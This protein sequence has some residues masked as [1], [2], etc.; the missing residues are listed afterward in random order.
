MAGLFDM[1]G[2]DEA[3][4]QRQLDEQRAAKF[5][6]QTQEQRLAG[7]GYKAGAGL[8]RGL[9][10]A[11]GV[12][13][14][15]PTIRQAAELRRMA[16][17][18]DVSSPEGLMQMAQALRATNPQMAVQ[19][20][21]KAQSMRESLAKTAKDTATANRERTASVPEK[22]QTAQRIAAIKQAIPAYE[23]A[24]DTASA[25]LLKNELKSL[26]PTASLSPFGKLLTEAG[27]AEGSDQYKKLVKDFA[28]ATLAGEKKGKGT[29]IT[30]V[31]GK[32]AGDIV[33]LRKDVQATTKP[34][35]DQL[36]AATDAIELANNA[37]KTGNFATVSTLSRSLAKA[38]GET[39]LSRTDVEAFG[40]DPSLVGGISDTVARLSKGRPTVDTLTKL[41]DLAT[42]LQAKADKKLSL[43]EQQT[44]NVAKASG[45]YS[46]SQIDTIFSRRPKPETKTE[47]VSMADAEAANLP[48]GT[49]IT[50]NGRRAR[51]E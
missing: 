28:D 15:D 19:L 36:D 8:G 21:E 39:Q 2:G 12:D 37:I 35:Q 46:D 24:G 26:E 27:I 4:M 44:R 45:N 31:V 6:E 9:A 33:S 14:T 43:E 30:N 18:Y 49:F 23:Q 32:D 13:V 25:Q 7:M 5:A 17:D 41:R 47:F 20:A 11:F 51:V 50:I 42:I 16:A 34:Y 48:K 22:L 10:G 29:T 3:A 40:A 38:A 1:L